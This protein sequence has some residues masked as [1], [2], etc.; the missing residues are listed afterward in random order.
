VEHDFGVGVTRERRRN[1]R[2]G[3]CGPRAADSGGLGVEERPDDAAEIRLREV[4]VEL[5]AVGHPVDKR[6]EGVLDRVGVVVGRQ[7]PPSGGLG[8]GN[9]LLAGGLDEEVT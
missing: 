8:L 1:R 3:V 5:V 4:G 2:I 6:G 9:R 7:R